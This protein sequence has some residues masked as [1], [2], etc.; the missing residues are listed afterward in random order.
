MSK[1]NL[2]LTPRFIEGIKKIP[3]NII[4]VLTVF[5]SPVYSIT[6]ILLLYLTSLLS[7]VAQ[8]IETVND[9][10]VIKNDK[11]LWG[12][13]PE[14]KPV[15]TGI[16]GDLEGDDDNYLFYQPADI[17]GDRQGNLY[18]L[19]GGNH[20]IQKFDRQGKYLSTTGRRGQGP[21]EFSRPT[22]I[23]L[24]AEGNIFVADAANQR[25]EIFNSGGE[26]LRSIR[27]FATNVLFRLLKNGD[28]LVRNPNLNG[29]RGLSKGNVPLFKIID[30]NGKTKS[31]FGQ[32]IYFTK[33]PSSTGGN[34]LLFD[35]DDND[36]AYVSFLFQN[37]IEKFTPDG[38]T[39][40]RADRPLNSKLMINKDLK[41]YLKNTWGIDVDSKGRIW[42]ITLRRR[43][44][45]EE[46]VHKMMYIDGASVSTELSGNTGLFETD[47][48][49]L[50]VFGSDGIL[51]GR[52]PLTH[53][54]D[55]L[56]IIDDKLYILDSIRSMRFYVYEIK[57]REE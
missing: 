47:M 35:T 37:R 38:R 10:K 57:Q 24:D 49:N 14:I 53:F 6:L 41:L 22:C 50:E 21:G 13:N 18:V 1:E 32:G 9:V 45:R 8:K 33:F 12:K 7:A 27:F 44:K 36:N 51:L 46:M 15:F 39:D 30:R 3:I 5:K 52:F 55:G 42:I 20:R 29:G 40:F 43:M 54:C 11:P 4:T 25:I 28:I 26:N 16:L 23:D 48:F 56:R 17:A 34:R 19:D 2:P 31:R